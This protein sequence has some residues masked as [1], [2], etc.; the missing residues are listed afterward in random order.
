MEGELYWDWWW[1]QRTE[2]CILCKLCLCSLDVLV[3]TLQP[4]L[5]E[6]TVLLTH[7]ISSAGGA[8]S[9]EQAQRLPCFGKVRDEKN[10]P[11]ARASPQLQ[12]L[13]IQQ[14]LGED[15]HQQPCRLQ[16]GGRS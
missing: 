2:S 3:Q 16:C 10:S 11:V 6:D 15:S 5:D 12:H 7:S 1:L 8:Q 13:Q 4:H 9:S 14:F